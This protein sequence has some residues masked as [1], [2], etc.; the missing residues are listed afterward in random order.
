[1]RGPTTASMIAEAYRTGRRTPREVAERALVAAEALD[2]EPL[3]LRAFI[4]VDPRDVRARADASSARWREGRPL[5]PLDGVP[6]AIK[7]EIDVAG[8]P[9]TCGTAFLGREPAHADAHVVARLRAAGAVILGKT[10]MHELG[11]G[12]SGFN[13]HHGAAR[14]PH[15]PARD[16]GGSSSGSAIAVASGVVPI[17]LGTD[18]GGS[19]RV[20]GSLSGV[21]SLKGTFGRVSTFGVRSPFRSMLC[22]GA[23]GACVSDVLLAS[24]AI[25]GEPMELPALPQQLRI[26]VCEGW[27]REAHPDVASAARRALELVRGAIERE[28]ELPHRE[29]AIPL[30]FAVLGTEAAA[31]MEPHLSSNQ[32]FSPSVRLALDLARGISPAQR[33]RALR[34]R[35]LVSRELER[36]L[37]RADVLITP[38]TAVA[39][40]IYR[41]DAFRSGAVDE[42]MAR[43]LTGYTLPANLAGLPAAQVPCGHDADEMPIGLQIVARRGEDLLALS[44]AAEIERSVAWRR[45]QAWHDILD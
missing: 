9:T 14:N 31:A 13:L 25:A 41:R 37:D 12:P 34:A 18:S 40:P 17:A 32:P 16:A 30:G 23:L 15:D 11:M 24:A 28:V 38:T 33:L 5:G 29:L 3:P 42:G 20:P 4:H 8:Q 36:A 19:L 6:V 22:C 1:M 10:N 7:D 26:A 2:R 21:A 27:W 45:P 43:A 39:A 44:V 35:A